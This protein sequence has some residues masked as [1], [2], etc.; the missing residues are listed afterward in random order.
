L[1]DLTFDN[2]L[3]P[4][5]TS[6]AFAGALDV[7]TGEIRKMSEEEFVAGALEPQLSASVPET[8]R[9]LYEGA[10]GA[11][12]YGYYFYPLFMLG[13]EQLFRVAEA[14]VRER[15]QQLRGPGKATFSENIQLLLDGRLID[16]AD[17]PRWDAFR[18]LRNQASHP[19]YQQVLP[20]GPTI[21]LLAEVA[22]AINQLFP[23][24]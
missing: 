19:R 20:P 3:Q 14:A 13:A 10:R 4:D 12:A 18:S 6:L 2:W 9:T 23:A 8:V 22:G 24:A 7:A 21:E 1:K 16:E 15:A 17:K 5:P 11:M